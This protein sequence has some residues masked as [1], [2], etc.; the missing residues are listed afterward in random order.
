MS[1]GVVPHEAFYLKVVVVCFIVS[2][3]CLIH[4]FSSFGKM[5]LLEPSSGEAPLTLSR[6]FHYTLLT[7]LC[8]SHLEY[9]LF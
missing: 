5:Y 4:L 2:S 3:L 6:L 7:E 8:F 1:R 9:I